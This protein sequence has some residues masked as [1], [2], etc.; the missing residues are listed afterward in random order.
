MLAN[1][2]NEVIFKK[3]FTDKLVFAEFVR[4]II[5]IDFEVDKIET[6]KRFSPKLAHVDF[7]L[8]I[9]AE[10]A[11]HRVIVEIQRIEYDHN[12]D[13]FLHYFLMSIAELQR[14][15]DI[16]ITAKTV[17]TIIVLTAPYRVIDKMGN[18]VKNE[19]LISELN[20]KNLKGDIVQIFGHKLVF[21]NSYYKDGET[22]S[23]IRDW[24]NLISE[25]IK[26]PENPNINLQKSGIN[27][28][29]KLIDVDNLT[30]DERELR[31]LAE[32]AKVAKKLYED[33]AEAKGEKIGIEK[34]KVIGKEEGEVIG[35]EK[36]KV[37]GIEEGKLEAKTQGI[38][39]ALQRNKLTIQEIAEDFEVSTDYVLKIKNNG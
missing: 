22:P 9:F 8:D 35:I 20:P 15:S 11:D 14:S 25:S 19:V 1:L 16:Y 3:A 34:G 29:S 32:T 6:E 38:I 24:M 28:A 2:D 37:L 12:F 5:G 33:D 31:K 17:Y 4:D 27:R 23:E 21:L 13:R 26:N 10:S 36:G 18:A 39:K 30:P 7:R